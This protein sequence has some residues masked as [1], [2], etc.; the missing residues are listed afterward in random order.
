MSK[1]FIDGT[2]IS[3]TPKGVGRYSFH[4]CEQLC[5][6]LSEK[7]EIEILLYDDCRGV[8]KQFKRLKIHY[9]P[10]CN[11]FVKGAFLLPRLLKFTQ[12]DL[13]LRPNDCLGVKYAVP[14][15]TVCHDIDQYIRDAQEVAS[16]DRESIV[17]R[18]LDKFKDKLIGF[19]LRC[20]DIVFC[21]SEFIQSA[22]C[23]YY[24]VDKKKTR[25]SYCAVEPRFYTISKAI[26]ESCDQDRK[27]IPCGNYILTFA[28]GD[29]RENFLQLPDIAKSINNMGIK[30]CIVVA[31]VKFDHEYYRTL[32]KLFLESRLVEGVDFIFLKFFGAESFDALVS[33]YAQADFYLDLSLHE[34][35]GMQVIEAMACGTTCISSPN[36]ALHEVCGGYAIHV[37]PTSS[38]GVA[39]VIVDAYGRNMHIRD[40][41]EQIKFTKKYN[42][43]NVG[44]IVVYEVN[45]FLARHV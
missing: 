32:K 16:G 30:T 39:S 33:L 6:K 3:K 20:S 42:W 36:G 45:K 9:H 1:L 22:V 24:S 14:S 2:T 15:M 23:Q 21:N 38:L 31:G 19:S 34:G 27:I 13:L 41:S 35:F 40:N 26:Q 10:R 29:H 37:D 7:W 25:I 43:D 11:D 28:T 18:S 17:R 5:R 12:P 8:L 4:L 44:D